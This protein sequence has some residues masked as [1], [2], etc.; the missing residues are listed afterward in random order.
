MDAAELAWLK[1]LEDENTRMRRIIANQTLE[2]D[3]IK[4]CTRCV[5]R[6][7]WLFVVSQL[8]REFTVTPRTTARGSHARG[9]SGRDGSR[10]RRHLD[11]RPIASFA[12]DFDA[13]LS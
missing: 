7:R 3:A 10:G 6:T 5:F 9:T 2:I 13:L 1:Q 12:A 8:V 11:E 4:K